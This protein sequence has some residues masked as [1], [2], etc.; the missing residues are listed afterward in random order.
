MGYAIR[1]GRC[2]L[3]SRPS[4]PPRQI[5]AADAVSAVESR[6]PEVGA[7]EGNKTP[8]AGWRAG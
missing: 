6:E 1:C 8:T 2:C 4:P 5:E 7:A 3:S